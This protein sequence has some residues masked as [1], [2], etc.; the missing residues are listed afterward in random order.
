MVIN[1]AISIE[2]IDSKP[3]DNITKLYFLHAN[4][5]ARNRMSL[6][7]ISI[8]GVGNVI[9]DESL[10]QRTNQLSNVNLKSAETCKKF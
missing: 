1:R 2:P 3:G 9:A 8:Q 7:V 4:I 10:S 5:T 6:T